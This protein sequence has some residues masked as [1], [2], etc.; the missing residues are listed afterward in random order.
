MSAAPDRSARALVERLRALSASRGGRSLVGTFGLV[1]VVAAFLPL[2]DHLGF[3][4]ALALTI[5]SAVAAPAVGVAAL[6]LELSRPGPGRRPVLAA[7]AA[8]LFAMLALVVPT[9][10]ILLNGL[11]RPV[12][13]PL[14]G[15][16]WLVVLPAPTAWL[17]A[18]L[19]GL[20]RVRVGSAGRAAVLVGAV[21]LA[22]L[23]VGLWSV[24]AGPAFFL[25]DHFFGY[26]P[27]PLYDETVLLGPTLL[28]FRGLTLLWGAAA[29]LGCGRALAD[30][31]RSRLASVGALALAMG[32]MATSLAFGESLGIRTTDKS[33]AAALGAVRRVDDLELHYPREWSDKQVDQL[34]RDAAFRAAQVEAA[35]EVKATRP[36]RVWV[37][38]SA[39]EKRRLVGA[40]GTSFSKPWRYE[41]HVNASGFAHPVLRHELVH[42]F[43]GFI[44]GGPFHAPGGLFPNS[45]LIEGFAVAFDAEP[46]GMTLSQWAKAMR[47]LKLAPDIAALLSSEG[48]LA[49]AP[50]RAYSYAG[51]FIRYLAGRFGT[52]KALELYRTGELG[53]LGDPKALVA[54]FEASLDAV[55]IRPEEKATA[56]RRFA[57][58]SVFHRRCAREVSAVTDEARDKLGRNETAEALALYDEACAL[59]PDDP[60]LVRGLLTAAI[61]AK[62]EARRA[63]AETRLFAHPKLDASLRASALIELGDEAWKKGAFDEA[64]IRYRAAA[65][66]EVDAATHRSA[67]ARARA[68]V[69]PGLATLLRPLLVDGNADVGQLFAM[70]DF[71]QLHPE[72]ALVAYLLGRQFTQR[73]AVVRGAQLLSSRAVGMLGDRELEREALRLA[74]RAWAEAHRCDDAELVRR[75][76][77]DDAASDRAFADDWIARCRF[78]TARGFEVVTR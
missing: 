45:P 38:R 40:S 62:D 13:D 51:A 75:A 77:P 66:L 53:T 23:F 7:F 55:V 19:G 70:N 25:F 44:A 22:A 60:A 26:Y 37:Y 15:A 42:A 5:A 39:E 52:A 71:V 8:A 24:Y 58:P 72:D 30:E 28:A 3:E 65:R 11:R 49:A 61:K 18:A 4:L 74:A 46:E 17:A 14:A 48:F 32:L 31:R 59:E 64:T 1:A 56:E 2:A 6:R 76:M 43:G 57:R 68:V 20:A 35:L 54:A 29:M 16:L 9:L 12:C 78:E 63:D 73:E 36:V 33:L 41:V 69:D 67:V 27:G 34:V 47:E 50:Q 21:E 10:L